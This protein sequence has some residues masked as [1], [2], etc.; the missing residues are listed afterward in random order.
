MTYN[1]LFCATPRNSS[2]ARVKQGMDPFRRRGDK[3]PDNQRDDPGHSSPPG[4]PTI[5]KY[6]AKIKWHPASSALFYRANFFFFFLYL[7]PPFSYPHTVDEKEEKKGAR[8]S[9]LR[10]KKRKR[11]RPRG[12]TR[13]CCCARAIPSWKTRVKSERDKLFSF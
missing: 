9:A 11:K 4:R 2:V 10:E 8:K 12:I 6:G 7:P 3:S 13:C 1:H 5:N